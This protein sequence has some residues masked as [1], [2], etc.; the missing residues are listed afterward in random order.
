[1]FELLGAFS[2]F[3]LIVNK[4]SEKCELFSFLSE[5]TVQFIIGLLIVCI[6]PWFFLFYL[7]F[8][9]EEE[10]FICGMFILFLFSILVYDF[11]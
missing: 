10:S 11:I 7:Y 8:F 5:F 9:I 3:N 2:D 4:G 1:M 6:D